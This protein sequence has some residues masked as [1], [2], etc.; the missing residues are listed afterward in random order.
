MKRIVEEA[1]TVNETLEWDCR[2]YVL[3]ILEAYEREAVLEK[4]DPDYAETK[5]TYARKRGPML[6]SMTRGN[7]ATVSA[8]SLQKS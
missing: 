7:Y 2:D 1:R 4:Q 3:Q 6:R 8:G 5:E